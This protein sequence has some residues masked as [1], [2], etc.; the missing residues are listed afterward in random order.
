MDAFDFL[1]IIDY[2]CQSMPNT[3]LYCMLALFTV[4]ESKLLKQADQ[5]KL[6]RD[7]LQPSRIRYDSRSFSVRCFISLAYW[8][9]IDFCSFF[10]CCGTLQAIGIFLRNR[11]GNHTGEVPSCFSLGVFQHSM[12]LNCSNFSVSVSGL[13]AC[14]PDS[15]V[16]E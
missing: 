16:Q 10:I 7:L 6:K 12:C 14:F 2:I 11:I 3:I 9:G 4:V 13:G 8:E 15:V 1:C 5:K